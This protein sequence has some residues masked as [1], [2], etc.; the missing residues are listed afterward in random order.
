MHALQVRNVPDALYD[1]LKAESEIH[2]RSLSGEIMFILEKHLNSYVNSSD[3]LFA[4]I[5]SVREKMKQKY[6]PTESSVAMIRED[7][8]R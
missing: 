4:G 2:H 1:K 7:R 6:G 3:D 5:V 8:D